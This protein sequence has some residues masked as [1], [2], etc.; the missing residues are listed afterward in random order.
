[1][2]LDSKDSFVRFMKVE[3]IVPPLV[4]K[5]LLDKRLGKMI[6]KQQDTELL[7]ATTRQ[8]WGQDQFLTYLE[9]LIELCRTEG[10]EGNTLKFMQ[11][12][13]GSLEAMKPE[14]SSRL[15]KTIRQFNKTIDAV[16]VGSQIQQ[17]E[18]SELTTGAVLAE[19]QTEKF[20]TQTE[21]AQVESSQLQSPAQFTT[22][23]STSFQKEALGSMVEDVT[24]KETSAESVLT[25][26][27]PSR[28]DS[29]AP[30]TETVVEAVSDSPSLHTS[31]TG[32]P[33]R[34]PPGQLGD[35]VSYTFT[36]EGGVLY[37][38]VHGVSVTI[39]PNAI[40]GHV[41]KF[42]LSMHFYL[43]HPFTLRED[44]NICSVVVWFHLHPPIEFLEDVTVEIPHAARADL[45]SLCVLTWGEDKQG[46]PYKLNTEVPAD[47]SDG[48]HAVFKQRHFSP[49]AVARTT[50]RYGDS[51]KNEI[52]HKARKK[53]FGKRAGTGSGS[54]S[55]SGSFQSLERMNS[56][57]I[58]KSFEE[59]LIK[60]VVHSGSAESDSKP[61][62]LPRQEAIDRDSPSSLEGSPNAMRYSVSCSM[63][64]DRSGGQWEVNI[65]ACLS[66]PTGNWVSKC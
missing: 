62:Q 33:H 64:R 66:H 16:T 52:L 29:A 38:P 46:P 32:A 42:F 13:K 54:G 37:S 65:A 23:Q 55:G 39:P 56:D 10:P 4:K 24:I 6:I 3:K 53:A 1:M 31:R 44:V 2:L 25:M 51:Y 9:V 30:L 49:H 21:Q 28:E 22:F 17:E 59:G 48:Y 45:T 8:Q 47:F 61:R 15:E 7:V 34:P 11:H 26:S 20:Q 63:P 12:M 57:S 43:G 58:D 14:P 60:L 19:Q 18:P 50:S 27:E 40:P 41:G 36:H 35:A 5:K